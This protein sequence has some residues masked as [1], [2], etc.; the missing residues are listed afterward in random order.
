MSPGSQILA[1]TARKATPKRLTIAKGKSL[2]LI[3]L[4]Y[5]KTISFIITC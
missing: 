2:V 3:K 4:N 5:K 1:L